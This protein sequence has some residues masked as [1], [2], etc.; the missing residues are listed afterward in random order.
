LDKRD[1]TDVEEYE[2]KIEYY[3]DANKEVAILCNHQKTVNK[4]FNVTSEKMQLELKDM[5][6]YLVELTEH[7]KKQCD[8]KSKKKEKAE[9]KKKADED[10]DKEKSK[11]KKV[12]PEEKE[13]TEKLMNNLKI[14]I[15]KA[16]KKLK[17]RVNITNIGRA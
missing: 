15:A 7:Y 6:D 3:N 4:N 12:F 17:S 10:D 11:L 2:S 14:K 16:E 8:K 5:I 13:K 1:L 9:R